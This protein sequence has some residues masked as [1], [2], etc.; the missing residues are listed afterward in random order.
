MKSG[1]NARGT[2]WKNLFDKGVHLLSEGGR[3]GIVAPAYGVKGLSFFT[4]Q[5]RKNREEFL[6]GIDGPHQARRGCTYERP[7]GYKENDR[8][9]DTIVQKRKDTLYWTQKGFFLGTEPG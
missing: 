8:R 6:W 2:S 1:Q 3:G 4:Q 7:E 5:R 9:W